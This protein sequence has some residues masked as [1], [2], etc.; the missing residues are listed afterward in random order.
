MST[1]GS[2]A[3]NKEQAGKER[4]FNFLQSRHLFISSINTISRSIINQSIEPAPNE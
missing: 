1:H 2:G 3:H 4:V